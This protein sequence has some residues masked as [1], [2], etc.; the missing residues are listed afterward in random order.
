MNINKTISQKV[1]GAVVLILIIFAIGTIGFYIL[2]DGLT[3]L[4]SLYLTVITLTTVGYG[5]LSPHSNMPADG[6]PYIIKV[7][8]LLLII[9]GMGA[10]LYTIGII[11]EYLVTGEMSKENRRRKMQ[12]K[13]STL[14][15]HY[16][17]CGAGETG[18]YIMQELRKTIRDFVVIEKSPERISFLENTIDN[19]LFI[20]GEADSEDNLKLAG[21]DKASGIVLALPDEKDNLYIVLSLRQLKSRLNPDLRIAAKAV[22]YEKT[23]PKLKNAGADIVISPDYISGRRMFSEMFRPAVTT[24]MDRMLRDKRAVM[25]IEQAV[26]GRGS[27]VAG[28]PLKDSGIFEKTGLLIA[29]V[30]KQGENGFIYNPG[31]DTFINYGDVLISIGSMTQIEKLRKLSGGMH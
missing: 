14:N 18:I 9:V 24:F 17:I 6:N 25:R 12:R 20:M 15:G 22:N 10:F 29:A 13:I 1:F 16:I 7:F 19:P 26:V 11:T 23:A 21:I 4:D 5:D 28:R 30:K 27:T 3:V 8:A 2:L 31:A